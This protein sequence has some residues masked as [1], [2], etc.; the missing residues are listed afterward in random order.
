MEHR[1]VPDLRFSENLKAAT[2][3]ITI[4]KAEV[5]IRTDSETAS[6][7]TLLGET[8][9]LSTIEPNQ[10][11]KTTITLAIHKGTARFLDL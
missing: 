5:A 4:K 3:V 11:T 1:E 8:S 7:A 10:S 9:V 2:K 6:K